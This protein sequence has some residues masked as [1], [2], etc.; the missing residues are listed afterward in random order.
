MKFVIIKTYLIPILSPSSKYLLS[1]CLIQEALKAA[2]VIHF[3]NPKIT[4]NR[5]NNKQTIPSS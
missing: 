5:Q 1:Q 3:I 4:E 2:T